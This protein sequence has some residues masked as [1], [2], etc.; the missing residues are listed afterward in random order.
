MYQIQLRQGDEF[1]VWTRPPG[2]SAAPYRAA[3][4]RVLVGPPGAEPLQVAVG[5]ESGYRPFPERALW[6]LDATE[7]S[8]L[9]ERARGGGSA[10]DDE[11]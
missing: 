6:V 10:A 8:A 3:R 5:G 11:P 9:L 4:V 1:V 2:D 7:A